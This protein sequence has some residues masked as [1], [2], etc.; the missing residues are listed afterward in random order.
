MLPR[1]IV[2]PVGRRARGA[3]NA[4]AARR[5]AD[6]FDYDRLSKRHAHTLGYEAAHGFPPALRPRTAQSL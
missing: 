1:L 4:K 3:C 5:A 2:Y 6:V